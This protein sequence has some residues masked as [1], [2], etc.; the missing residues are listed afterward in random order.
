MARMVVPRGDPEGLWAQDRGP[1]GS[2]PPG[3]CPHTSGCPHREPAGGKMGS[4]SLPFHRPAGPA[5]SHPWSLH[6]L[7]LPM[8]SG[9][10]VPPTLPPSFSLS[11]QLLSCYR[12]SFTPGTSPPGGGAV[13]MLSKCLADGCRMHLTPLPRPLP[14]GGTLGPRMTLHLVKRCDHVGTRTSPCPASLGPTQ[15]VAGPAAPT[16]CPEVWGSPRVLQP[17]LAYPGVHRPPR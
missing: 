12:P 15:D 16:T 14:P 2:E 5:L 1:W 3:R 4:S 10:L 17:G 13:L 11:E 7:E 8:C 6:L 9:T